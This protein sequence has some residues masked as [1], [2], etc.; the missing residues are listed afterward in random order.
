MDETTMGQEV[1]P[2]GTRLE[3]VGDM[4]PDDRWNVK[5][6]SNP[7]RYPRLNAVY[8]IRVADD[9]TPRACSVEDMIAID[10]EIAAG[11]LADEESRPPL[12]Y[13][14]PYPRHQDIKGRVD[15]GELHKSLAKNDSWLITIQKGNWPIPASY[16]MRGKPSSELAYDQ[17]DTA[18][19]HLLFMTLA[20]REIQ[21]EVTEAA[22]YG[23][24]QRLDT[25]DDLGAHEK[26][27]VPA[28]VQGTDSNYFVLPSGDRVNYGSQNAIKVIDHI[29]DEVCFP[30]LMNGLLGIES[31]EE[32]S[33]Y[34]ERYTRLAREPFEEFAYR[35]LGESMPDVAL[36][37][38]DMIM[39]FDTNP[40]I[41]P[42]GIGPEVK[43][44]IN[45]E[46]KRRDEV[47]GIMDQMVM[48]SNFNM[49]HR[50]GRNMSKLEQV[51]A[52]QAYIR[53]I[54]RVAD[55]LAGN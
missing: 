5:P 20:P 39:L 24:N 48:I 8:G 37:R 54:L 14:S 23:V 19:N 9:G 52:S 7:N 33:A 2:Q 38:S 12:L 3:A 27:P 13:V 28:A 21:A 36:S 41:I 6:R 44:W 15:E 18:D 1:L 34:M 45:L 35:L 55:K 43:T 10:Q 47:L 25:L 50:E 49:L 29:S 30:Q 40:E 53:G 42:V 22:G 16:F 46:M 17:H 31:S 11:L 26:G 32:R 4:V 51:A